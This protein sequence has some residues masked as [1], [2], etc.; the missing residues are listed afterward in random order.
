M[1]Q[2]AEI[3]RLLA[4]GQADLLDRIADETVTTDMEGVAVEVTGTY[5]QDRYM[6]LKNKNYKKAELV[7]VG[8]MDKITAETCTAQCH[9]DNNPTAGADY[10]FDFEQRRTQGLHKN[11]GL[12]YE[13]E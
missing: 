9:N 7:A 1:C 4:L 3:G 8:L 11:F 12:K 2:A 6:S 13:H 10:T 5:V